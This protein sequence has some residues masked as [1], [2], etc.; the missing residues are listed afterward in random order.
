MSQH[1]LRSKDD[2]RLAPGAGD[3]PAQ[4]VKILR[5][6]GRLADLHVFFAGELHKTLDARA[7]V[8]RA[9]S[10]V[11]VREKHDQTGGEVPLVFPSADELIDDNLRAIR[12]ISKLALPP[13][14]GLRVIP[15]KPRLETEPAGL[16]KR[17]NLNF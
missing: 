8:L 3:L 6:G 2:E 4:Q 13:N 9:L 17:R 15:A 7:R 14:Q 16:R 12:E 10:L 11:A 5:G 1:T